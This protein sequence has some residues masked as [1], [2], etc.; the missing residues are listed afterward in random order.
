MNSKTKIRIYRKVIEEVCK[1]YEGA[2]EFIDNKINE[3]FSEHEISSG[4]VY[5]YIFMFCY[6]AYTQFKVNLSSISLALK[7]MAYKELEQHIFFV[8][9]YQEQQPLFSFGFIEVDC[10]MHG[11]TERNLVDKNLVLQNLNKT[12][13]K[14]EQN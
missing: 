13:T 9:V 14:F 8:E 10:Y 11:K 2:R 5:F 4:E 3:L 7:C 1:Q 12:N 6:A